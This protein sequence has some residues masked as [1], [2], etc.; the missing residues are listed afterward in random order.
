MAALYES[1][2]ECMQCGTCT[3][4]CPVAGEMDYTPRQLIRLVALGLG[5]KAIGS[6]GIWMCA[7]CTHC[8]AKC[9]RSIDIAEMMYG[10]R[11]A[12]IKRGYAA[13]PGM[14]FT[15]SFLE[16][17]K[18]HGRAF[19]VELLLRYSLKTNPLALLGQVGF[20]LTLLRRGKVSPLPDRIVDREQVRAILEQPL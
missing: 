10:L 15:K 12:A 13:Q 14:I 2:K 16:V 20:G 4:T 19:E 9:P 11:A 6:T 1:L 18:E 7:S 8:S 17:V 3:A 5:E